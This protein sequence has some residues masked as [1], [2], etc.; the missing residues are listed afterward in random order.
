VSE[1]YSRAESLLLLLA[2]AGVLRRVTCKSTALRFAFSYRGDT[3]PLPFSHTLDVAMEID[4]DRSNPVRWR[5]FESLGDRAIIG[6]NADS[7]LRY[8]ACVINNRYVTA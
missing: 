4:A 3:C 5:T 8:P 6:I 2:Q 1:E 7:R